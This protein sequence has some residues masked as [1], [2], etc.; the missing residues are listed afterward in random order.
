MTLIAPT[1]SF[2]HFSPKHLTCVHSA[3]QNSHLD[4]HR[5]SRGGFLEGAG[6]IPGFD[7]G[8]RGR[9]PHNL[10][11]SNLQVGLGR[12]EHWSKNMERGRV[13]PSQFLSALGPLV[14]EPSPWLLIPSPTLSTPTWPAGAGKGLPEV[15]AVSMRWTGPRCTGVGHNTARFHIYSVA[16]RWQG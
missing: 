6:M 11:H 13:L 8:S 2:H 14:P 10:G 9:H 16:G 3:D 5:Y 7:K 15:F 12:S 1:R 4:S